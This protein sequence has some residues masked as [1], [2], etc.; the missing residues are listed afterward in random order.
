MLFPVRCYDPENIDIIAA[1]GTFVKAFFQIPAQIRSA[2]GFLVLHAQLVAA[3]D[4]SFVGSGSGGIALQW[5]QAGVD[6][7]DD[8]LGI[9][10]EILVELVRRGDPVARADDDGRRIQIIEAHVGQI[11]RDLVEE[12]ASCAGVGGQDDT[13]GLLD[14]R[15]EVGIIQRDKRRHIDDVGLD[16]VFLGE[17]LG[18]VNRAVERCADGK[19]GEILAIADLIDCAGCP[20]IFFGGNAAL[21]E[22]FALAI[23]TL[24]LKDDAGIGAVQ[25]R[26][27]NALGL[28]RSSREED[29]QA[30]DVRDDGDPVLRMLRAVLCTDGHTQDHRHLENTGRHSLPLGHLVEDLVTCTAKEVAVHQLDDRA[31]AAH[32]VAD[33]SA[34]NGSLGNRR[35]EQES[36]NMAYEVHWLRLLF[37]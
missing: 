29:L 20:L 32:A 19:D 13:A 6:R 26:L 12:R 8:P 18:C 21:V 36:T 9:R 27:H 37:T 7:V 30:G 25:S 31:A 34:N 23:D 24:G 3:D 5:D 4:L 28:I 17:R 16:A 33:G 14:G 11:L 15:D 10:E 35:V 1:F 2:R 22:L